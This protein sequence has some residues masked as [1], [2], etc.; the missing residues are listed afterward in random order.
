M[1]ENADGVHQTH[2]IV[3]K[4][5]AHRIE[6]AMEYDVIATWDTKQQST[7]T[8][9]NNG[10]L[11]F[12]LING[13]L[14]AAVLLKCAQAYIMCMTKGSSSHSSGEKKTEECRSEKPS[15]HKLYF[16]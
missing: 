14:S 3:A 1:T 9:S 4:K 7:A 2:Q 15:A 11:R 16:S 5:C 8:N 12:T 10:E 6:Q 13:V